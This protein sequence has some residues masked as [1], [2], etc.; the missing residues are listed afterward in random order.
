[1]HTLPI[2]P[3]SLN[4]AYRGRRFKTPELVAYKKLIF[5]TAPAIKIP[6]GKLKVKYIFGVS[7]MNSDV[8]NLVKCVQDSLAEKYGFNDKLIYKIEVEKV[9]VEK[10]KEF[11]S[12]DIISLFSCF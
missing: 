6:E 9:D 5:Y 1:M 12:F 4:S 7:S 10:G 11:I 8:D 2:K 3:I